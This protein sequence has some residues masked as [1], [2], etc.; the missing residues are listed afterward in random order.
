MTNEKTN[1]EMTKEKGELTN[2]KANTELPN[3]KDESPTIVPTAEAEDGCL[4]AE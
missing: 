1:G 4:I 2:A 3:V